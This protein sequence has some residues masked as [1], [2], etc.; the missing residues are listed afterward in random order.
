M[1][2][3]KLPKG[4]TSIESH[5]FRDCSSLESVDLPEGLTSIEPLAFD[6]CV[7][8]KEIVLPESLMRASSDSFADCKNLTIFCPRSI[9]D[10]LFQHGDDWK[11]EQRI[12]F[13]E[14][15]ADKNQD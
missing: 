7:S 6:G 2:H 1:K 14:K 8:L 4:L 9:S 12:V 11:G 3:I 10:R 13:F 15:D 5:A